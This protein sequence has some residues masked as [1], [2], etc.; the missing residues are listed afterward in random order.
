MSYHL[1]TFPNTHSAMAAKAWLKDKTD[2]RIMPT[3]REISDSCGI[4]I[5]IE[6]MEFE[7][8]EKIMEA[9]PLDASTM[10][11]IYYV[12]DSVKPPL[13]ARLH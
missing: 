12:D 6:H 8:L 11:S 4:S 1:I 7:K 9:S 5:K 10:F 2:C 3:L 13:I